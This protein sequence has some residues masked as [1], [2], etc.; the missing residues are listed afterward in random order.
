MGQSL[1]M[2]DVFKTMCEN[3]YFNPPDK[4]QLTYPCIMYQL[5][6]TSIFHASNKI[7][8]KHKRYTVT[9]IDRDPDSN[10]PDLVLDLPYCNHDRTFVNDN[11]YHYVFT[12]YCSN[13][14]RIYLTT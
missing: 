3:V 8:A 7:Y 11:L 9:V 13:D 4:M 1:P 12:L 14:G 5:D 10:I 6:N 2:F